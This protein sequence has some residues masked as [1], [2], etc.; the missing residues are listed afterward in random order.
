MFLLGYSWLYTFL[1][2]CS[3]CLLKNI[4][5]SL[6]TANKIIFFFSKIKTVGGRIHFLQKSLQFYLQCTVLH[7]CTFHEFMSLSHFGNKTHFHN[8][9]GVR[10]RIWTNISW[11]TTQ[12]KYFF[13]QNLIVYVILTICL[14]FTQSHQII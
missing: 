4:L 2:I 13:F 3:P 11:P 12:L 8:K 7:F 10:M 5:N 14:A 9:P 1:Y 6:R